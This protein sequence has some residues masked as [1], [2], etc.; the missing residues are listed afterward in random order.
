MK[1]IPESMKEEKPEVVVVREGHVTRSYIRYPTPKPTER[2]E[3]EYGSDEQYR[4]D[5]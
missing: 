1:F 3:V 4:E 2:D 5:L